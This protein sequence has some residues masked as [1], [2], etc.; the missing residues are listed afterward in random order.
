[1]E[2]GGQQPGE[3]GDEWGK[4]QGKGEEEGREQTGKWG[5]PGLHTQKEREKDGHF[6]T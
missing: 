1:M 2:E 4:Q 5:T 6:V 3:E